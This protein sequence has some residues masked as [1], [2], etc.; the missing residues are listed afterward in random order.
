MA[1]REV[2]A[3]QRGDAVRPGEAVAQ[4]VLVLDGRPD[5][6]A[7]L[8][9]LGAHRAGRV[10]RGDRARPHLGQLGDGRLDPVLR[11]GPGGERRGLGDAVD[12]ERLP[13]EGRRHPLD[14]RRRGRR[15]SRSATP[16]S[17]GSSRSSAGRACARR[18]RDA[19][20]ARG[21]GRPSK[22]TPAYAS[23]ESS[24]ASLPAS[25]AAISVEI[26][27]AEDVAGRVHRRVHD[28]ERRLG[29]DRRRECLPVRRARRRRRSR[30]TCPPASAIDLREEERRGVRDR[31]RAEGLRGEVEAL[32]PAERD[33]HLAVGIDRAPELGT[34]AVRDRLAQRRQAARRRV[35]GA[36]RRLRPPPRRRAA[37]CR[38][39]DGRRSRSGPGSAR[40]ARATAS[41]PG[42]SHQEPLSI[43]T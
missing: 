13:L 22:R 42:R 28:R 17:R 19:T 12:R 5:E 39:T 21:A 25:A 6:G 14:H 37:A 36:P 38:P 34:D 1:A 30:R 35:G 4:L 40:R 2:A 16:P 23:S 9:E 29:V 24:S 18:A 8:G 31:P 41:G 3:R 32:H 33:Q 43:A 11:A 27:R 26:V 7:G 10:R 20:P 15:R